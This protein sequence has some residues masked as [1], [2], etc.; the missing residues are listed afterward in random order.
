MVTNFWES[1]EVQ[2]LY[3]CSRYRPQQTVDK[4]LVINYKNN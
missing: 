1:F 2:N 3:D 4:Y